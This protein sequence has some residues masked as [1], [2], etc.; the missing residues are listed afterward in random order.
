MAADQA[1][2]C[3]CET[4]R[5]KVVKDCYQLLTDG[6]LLEVKPEVGATPAAGKL[7]SAPGGCRSNVIRLVV[8]KCGGGE[9]IWY[10][11][12]CVI[13][14]NQEIMTVVQKTCKRYCY[15]SGSHTV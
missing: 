3:V 9:E 4:G 11:R 6:T 15:K 2:E 10:V 5:V 12:F 13:N 1:F 14:E 8:A 7:A